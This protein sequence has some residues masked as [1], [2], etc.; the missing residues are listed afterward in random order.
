MLS[1]K[2]V[3]RSV[4]AG[5]LMPGD[6]VAIYGRGRLRPTHGTVARILYFDATIL[7]EYRTGKQEHLPRGSVVNVRVD[8]GATVV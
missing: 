4:V 7:V 1:P 8:P 3:Y 6:V 2:P 5:N